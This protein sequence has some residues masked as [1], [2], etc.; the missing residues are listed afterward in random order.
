VPERILIVRLAALGDA[1][2]VSVLLDRIRA[3]LPDARVTWLCGRST[4]EIVALFGPDEIITVNDRALAG[5]LLSRVATVLHAWGLL[6][7]QR[8][9]DR[10]IVAHADRR[11]RL[12]CAPARRRQFRMLRRNVPGATNPIPGRFA[13]D[14]Y[15]RLLDP[16]ERSHG[17]VMRRYL[18]V[19][20]R[21]RLPAALAEPTGAGGPRRIVLV[22]G[23]AKNTLRENPMRRWPVERYRAL[24]EELCAAGHQVFLVGDRH[25][26]WAA[27]AFEGLPVEDRIGRLTLTET[28]LLLRDSDL[29]ISHDTGPMHLARA[30]RTRRIALFGPTMPSQFVVADDETTILWGGARLACRPCYDGVEFARCRD[31]LCMQ[32]I[33]VDQVLNAANRMLDVHAALTK[34]P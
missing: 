17:P 28:L 10:V 4:A 13:G 25:D 31:N 15:A 23:G 30:V 11:Y 8:R 26:A 6:L 3:E 7:R 16:D 1:V 18:P 27:A 32:D 29:V 34:V 19:D 24:A 2:M 9:F 14:E 5:S 33:A 21:P 22:P 20:V 12:L